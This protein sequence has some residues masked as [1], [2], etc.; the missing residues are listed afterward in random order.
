M[1]LQC[2]EWDDHSCSYC[3]TDGINRSSVTCCQFNHLYK[4]ETP[5]QTLTANQVFVCIST[6]YLKPTAAHF[7]QWKWLSNNQLPTLWKMNSYV[8]KSFLV[9]G[10]KGGGVNHH[11]T[12]CIP[13]AH[14]SIVYGHIYSSWLGPL[15]HQWSTQKGARQWHILNHACWSQ[16]F[17]EEN[18]QPPLCSLLF[19]LKRKSSS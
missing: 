18:C 16:S 5:K 2:D 8:D 19:I 17:T 15:S 11:F 14:G 4:S 1:Q 9:C 6:A 13:E 12:L 10:L 7:K 3:A